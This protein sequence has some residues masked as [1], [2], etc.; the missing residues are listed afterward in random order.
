MYNLI[1]TEIIKTKSS[2][3]IKGR[4]KRILENIFGCREN[5]NTSFLSNDSTRYIS[6]DEEK[7]VKTTKRKK[8]ST[9]EFLVD[10]MNS[11][12]QIAERKFELER[13]RMDKEYKLQSER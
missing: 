3:S 7:E 4:I 12:N 1:S 13:D 5:I 9:V 8:N 11:I 10:D 6:N 2:D